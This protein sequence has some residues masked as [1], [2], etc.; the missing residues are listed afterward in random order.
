MPARRLL[1][2]GHSYVV[3]AN[4]RLAHEMSRAG[5]GTWEVTAAAPF[6]FP[7]QRDLGT[8]RLEVPDGESSPVVPLPAYLTR[9]VHVFFYGRRLHD[10]LRSG[11]DLV[12]CWEEP[13]ILAG[14]QVR[15]WL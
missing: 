14:A 10:L 11:W 6:I 15:W 7:G 3:T 2:M 13:Y 5:R 4:R 12:H 1:T 9:R 8:I